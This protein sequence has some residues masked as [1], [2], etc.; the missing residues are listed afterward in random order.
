MIESWMFSIYSQCLG[1]GAH[2]QDA[3]KTSRTTVS[4]MSSIYLSFL[5]R[6]A[7]AHDRHRPTS[8][9]RPRPRPADQRDDHDQG[10]GYTQSMTAHELRRAV[11]EGVIARLHR[12]TG[13]T[14]RSSSTHFLACS[15]D[16][17]PSESA[18][19]SNAE[20]VL[21]FVVP[22]FSNRRFNGSENP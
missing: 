11:S 16:P 10:G 19:C 20:E 3:P 13:E 14:L 12:A 17:L 1:L 9:V 7:P 6:V 8:Q 4:S 2:A 5:A 22:T 21:A 18:T 15:V